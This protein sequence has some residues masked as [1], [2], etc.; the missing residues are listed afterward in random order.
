MPLGTIIK[1]IM[2][3]GSIDDLIKLKNLITKLIQ[4]KKP[5][6]VIKTKSNI[7]MDLAFEIETEKEFEDLTQKEILEAIARRVVSLAIQWD[8]DAI[9]YCDAYEIEEE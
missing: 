7:M 6:V 2:A 9:G 3:L 1:T 8:K 4:K 5:N